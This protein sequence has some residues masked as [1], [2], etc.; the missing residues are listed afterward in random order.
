MR[1]PASAFGPVP[2][3][4]LLFSFAL[5]YSSFGTGTARSAAGIVLLGKEVPVVVRFLN[6]QASGHSIDFIDT[7][8]A[9]P[10]HSI[11][12]GGIRNTGNF[13]QLLLVA[14]LLDPSGTAIR[15]KFSA[16]A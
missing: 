11:C 7:E 16:Y 9:A 3:G 5:Q 1:L 10:G 15:Q 14:V 2:T 8:E 4:P 6:A 13:S 12:H